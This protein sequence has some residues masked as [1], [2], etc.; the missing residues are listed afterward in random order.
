[1]AK[2]LGIRSVSSQLS[3]L[4]HLYL[5]IP[6]Q[7]RSSQSLMKSTN[8][9]I[10]HYHI[11]TENDMQ[12]TNISFPSRILFHIPLPRGTW[13]DLFTLEPTMESGRLLRRLK[14][15]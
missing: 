1:M 6:I 2:K 5:Y 10:Q 7:V 4:S 14:N 8:G 3:N 13:S 11:T 12:I 15:V 9:Y